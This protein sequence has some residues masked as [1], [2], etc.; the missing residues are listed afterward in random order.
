VKTHVTWIGAAGVVLLALT[1]TQAPVDTQSGTTIDIG[2]AG[3]ANANVSIGSSGTFVGVAWAARTK[4]DVT[5]IYTAM[6]RDGGRSFAAPVRVNQMPGEASV[7]GEQPPRIVL[8]PCQSGDPAMVVVWTAKSASSTRLVSARSTDGGKSF[9]PAA[10]VPGSDASGNRGWES[11]AVTATGD[12]VAVWVDH[13][14]APTRTPDAT[15]TGHQHGATHPRSPGERLARAQLSQIFFAS[16]NQPGSAR[17]IARGVCY[18]CKTSVATSVDGTVVA[19]WRHVYPGSIRDIALAT[20]S[21]GGR[22]F[23]PPVRVSEDNWVLD[24]C[25]E[26]GPAIAL[27]HANAIHVVWPTLIPDS[28]G[29]EP[30][31][32]LFYATSKDGQRFTTRQLIPTEGVPRHPQIA[33]GPAGTITVVWDEQLKGERRIVVARGTSGDKNSLHF[34]RQPLSDVAGT[35]PAVTSLADAAIVTWTS[36]ATEDSVLRVERHP[37]VR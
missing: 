24:G 2:L 17:A 14:D 6:S 11:A 34:V 16:L 35:Y 22:T 27:D 18:C 1:V 3:R 29:A 4:D 31:M 19:A 15:G 12:V 10:P 26:N 23:A 5:D 21:D 8:T 7:S 20:S 25:P 13:R 33:I 28:A 9:G 30:T 32:A 36:G 37:A